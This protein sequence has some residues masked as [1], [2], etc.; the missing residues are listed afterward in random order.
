MGDQKQNGSDESREKSGQPTDAPEE[1]YE[2]YVEDTLSMSTMRG[3][4][5]SEA[6]SE[7]TS[8]TDKE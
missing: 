3:G 7:L 5:L 2:D 1:S 6:E 4:G 8:F